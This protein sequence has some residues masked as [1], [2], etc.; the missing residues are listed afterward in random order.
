MA[1]ATV[2]T[3]FFSYASGHPG[4]GP[5][6]PKSEVLASMTLHFPGFEQ[7]NKPMRRKNDANRQGDQIGRIFSQLVIVYF[8]QFLE[9]YRN[10][11]YC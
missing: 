1:W 9:S 3:V 10:S 8:W 6:R 11:T 7:K 5:K 4:R 2:W